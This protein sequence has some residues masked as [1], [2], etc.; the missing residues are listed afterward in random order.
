MEQYENFYINYKIEE[1]V[2]RDNFL[3][4][5]EKLFQRNKN[6]DIKIAD[7]IKN[8]YKKLPLFVDPDHPSKYLMHEIGKRIAEILNLNDIDQHLEYESCLGIPTPV[9]PCVRKF[10]GL[11][12]IV[13]CEKM[14]CPLEVKSGY[15]LRE[16]IKVYLWWYHEKNLI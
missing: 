1:K 4:D 10:F 3:R 13:P 16:Y 15:G 9:I 14:R 7:F 6:W 5:M 8:N 12:F 2:L 11:D